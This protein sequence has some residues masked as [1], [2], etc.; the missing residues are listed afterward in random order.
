M[1]LGS[2][3]RKSNT[4]P[5]N[6]SSKLIS[7]SKK[8]NNQSRSNR[9]QNNKRKNRGQ[10]SSRSKGSSNNNTRKTGNSDSEVGGC[11]GSLQDCVNDCV[12][13]D[14]L[15]AYTACV[16]VCGNRCNE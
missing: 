10:T 5:K 11:P 6:K 13:L 3:N 8:T 2:G 4:K 1:I 7:Q 12:P 14:K 15:V 9:A 16:K